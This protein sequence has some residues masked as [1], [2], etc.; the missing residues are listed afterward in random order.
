MYMLTDDTWWNAWIVYQ[1]SNSGYR[2]AHSDETYLA[3]LEADCPGS[4]PEGWAYAND[5]TYNPV[6][7]G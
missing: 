4:L 6:Y 5:I 7:K 1:H 2:P 3:L